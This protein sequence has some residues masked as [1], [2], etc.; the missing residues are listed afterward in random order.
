MRLH[1]PAG[2]LRRGL[3]LA[4][5][6]LLAAAAS[7]AAR[8]DDGPPPQAATK[9][10]EE[11]LSK[12]IALNPGSVD[13]RVALARLR[14]KQDRAGEGI[15]ALEAIVAAGPGH[16]PAQLAL[17]Q[18]LL[19][20]DRHEDAVRA[21]ERAAALDSESPAAWFGL[22]QAALGAGRDSR[23]EEALAQTVRRDSNPEWHRERVYAAFAL[24]RDEAVV[25]AAKAFIDA[26]GW[27]SESAPYVAYA[28]ALSSMR[29]GRQA[30][31]AALLRQVSERVPLASWQD[32]V[33]QFLA[34]QLRAEQLIAKADD[35]GERTEARAYA[36][37]REAVAG[38]RDEALPHLRWVK[39]RGLKHYLEYRMATATLKRLE[40]PPKTAGQ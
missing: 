16:F 15:A 21:F 10:A 25:R 34:G 37:M 32:L 17:A 22:S 36:G 8:P 28:S 5:L 11:A 24:G 29:L 14:G 38:R 4:A 9:D 13:A 20:A 7:A 12:T 39:E 1:A 2:S 3:T 27:G 18:L 23:S 40:E 33:A 30:E 31:A 19:D 26:A 6:L 35:D